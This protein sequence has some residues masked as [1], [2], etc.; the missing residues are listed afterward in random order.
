MKKLSTFIISDV[1]K[2]TLQE[3][4]PYKNTFLGYEVE[5]TEKGTGVILYYFLNPAQK[6]STF[7]ASV[8]KK[9]IQ[10]N[11]S[12]FRCKKTTYLGRYPS[13]SSVHEYRYLLHH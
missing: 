13:L 4:M 5:D 12:T 2:M 9:F 6:Y 11:Q 10:L 7:E 8:T 3:A 1:R